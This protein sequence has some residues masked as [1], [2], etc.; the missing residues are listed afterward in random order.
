MSTISKTVFD[1][2]GFAQ[3]QSLKGPLLHTTTQKTTTRPTKLANN[4]L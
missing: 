4:V 2:M 1:K 3:V